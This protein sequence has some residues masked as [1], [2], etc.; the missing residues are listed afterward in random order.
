MRFIQ[1]HVATSRQTDGRDYPMAEGPQHQLT[2]LSFRGQVVGDES[3][4]IS[5]MRRKR[6]LK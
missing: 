5:A 1:P 6:K 4:D 2:L 3:I